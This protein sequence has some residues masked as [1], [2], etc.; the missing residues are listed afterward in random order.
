MACRQRT[1]NYQKVTIPNS[2]TSHGVTA[3]FNKIC[4]A[5]MGYQKRIEIQPI[6]NIVL[7]GTRKTTRYPLR[8]ERKMDRGGNL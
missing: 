7:R 8:K 5:R 2:S 6:F 1:I 3:D 4:G